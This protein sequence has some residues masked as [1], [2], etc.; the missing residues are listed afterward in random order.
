M[1]IQRITFALILSLILTSPVL[2]FAGSKPSPNE[3][4]GVNEYLEE[5]ELIQFFL[6]YYE[7]S[8][9]YVHRINPPQVFID[10]EEGDIRRA[11]EKLAVYSY[12]L[13]LY[14]KY[15]K[16]YTPVKVLAYVNDKSPP[17][18]EEE[19]ATEEENTWSLFK[20][21]QKE[22]SNWR[23]GQLM[24]RQKVEDWNKGVGDVEGVF[25]SY[26]DN[27]LKENR[28]WATKGSIS[29]PVQF[30]SESKGEGED[31]NPNYNYGN[32]AIIP[33]IKWN[34]FDLSDDETKDAEELT[35]ITSFYSSVSHKIDGFDAYSARS[36]LS[37]FRSDFYLSPFYSTDFDF[38]GEI[39]GTNLTYEPVMQFGESFQTGS[40]HKLTES[41]PPAYLLRFI[42]GLTYSHVASEGPFIKRE[43]N[44]DS[45]G[46]TASFEL[47]CIV[48]SDQPNYY[49]QL[50]IK[51]KYFKNSKKQLLAASF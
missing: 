16:P 5:P 19:L 41:L 8:Y 50:L 26:A 12:L 17:E 43:K 27:R 37:S 29:Y 42:P 28:T 9:A 31:S 48:G 38:D 24:F 39:L 14:D 11:K 13:A 45:F 21:Y 47:A 23:F 44:D 35:F 4:K 18:I 33:S 40:W 10:A 7:I 15:T 2:I 34:Y 25:V 22:K 30:F 3:F 36:G 49:N 20:P 51:D 46:T 6:A 1:K 32:F